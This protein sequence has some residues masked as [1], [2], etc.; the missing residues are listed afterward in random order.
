MEHFEVFILSFQIASMLC[1]FI[2]VRELKMCLY[3]HWYKT[4]IST[5]NKRASSGI[6][7]FRVPVFKFG[8]ECKVA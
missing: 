6:F 8:L 1:Q 7:N 2:Q 3:L 4:L 5:G